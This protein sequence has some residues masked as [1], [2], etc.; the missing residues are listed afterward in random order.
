LRDLDLLLAVLA[1]V[2][3]R[4]FLALLCG[5]AFLALSFLVRVRVVLSAERR[6]AG[7]SGFVTGTD[8]GVD[9]G[10]ARPRPSPIDLANWDRRSE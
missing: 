3:R 5:L 2:L 9:A 8:A 1:L 7:L 4:V 10:R 6:R